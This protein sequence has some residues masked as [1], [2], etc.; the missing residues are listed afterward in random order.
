MDKKQMKN[1]KELL[2]ISK[3][4]LHEYFYNRVKPEDERTKEIIED[5]KNIVKI[6]EGENDG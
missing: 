4:L 6:I 1:Y 2:Q 5:L 3:M